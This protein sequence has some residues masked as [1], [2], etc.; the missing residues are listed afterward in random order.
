MQ[1]AD[2]LVIGGGIAGLSTLWSLC[3]RGARSGLAGRLLLV[4][5]E[6]I[7]GSAASG[8][9]A[10]I[11]RH[12]EHDAVSARL[13]SR[14]GALLAELAPGDELLRRTGAVY[15]SSNVDDLQRLAVLGEEQ[16]MVTRFLELGE[17]P[18]VDARLEGGEVRAR[19]F[20]ED[21]GVLD[22]HGLLER[23]RRCALSRGASI[24]CNT[25]VERILVRGGRVVGVMLDGGEEIACGRIVLASGAWSASLGKSAGASIPLEPF[26]RHL[27]FLQ[28]EEGSGVSDGTT[29]WR[30]DD[31]VYARPESG[32]FLA[33]PC[34]ET[35]WPAAVSPETDKQVLLELADRLARTMPAIASSVVRRQW[36][37]LRTFA[38][39]RRPVVGADPRVEGLYWLAGLGGQ[40]LST[41]LAGAEALARV[42]NEEEHILMDA[43]SPARTLLKTTASPS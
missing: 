30:V 29:I 12:L 4:E 6:P 40:G 2:T 25:T 32:G 13:A 15:L 43:L 10:G 34:D 38:P 24:R 16:A 17:M 23:L 41:A 8:R 19:L 22:V 33:S 7:C 11:F 27:V 18:S 5:K 42:M 3:V 1:Q 35:P 14:T 36:A 28:T 37:C 26:R 21:D 20:V 31:Q 39:D 9:N